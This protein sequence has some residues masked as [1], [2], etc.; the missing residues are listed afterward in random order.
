MKTLKM[1]HI[2]RYLNKVRELG[3]DQAKLV[4]VAGRLEVLILTSGRPGL[5]SQ[6]TPALEVQMDQIPIIMSF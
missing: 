3:N 5:E 1:A 4:N 6:L 2:E